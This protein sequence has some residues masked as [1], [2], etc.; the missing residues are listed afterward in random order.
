MYD[1]IQHFN[2]WMEEFRIS[3][4]IVR[5]ISNFSPTSASKLFMPQDAVVTALDQA[6][7]PIEGVTIRAS[8]SGRGANVNPS[9]AVTDSDGK[10]RFK[11]RFGLITNNG[12]IVFTANGLSVVIVQE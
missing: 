10:A 7:E 1:E 12:E 11:F 6:G 2:G 8:A 4:G 3:K 9:Q 5:W